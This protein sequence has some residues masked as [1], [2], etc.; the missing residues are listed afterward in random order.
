MSD[1]AD[2]D[3]QKL[4]KRWRSGDPEAGQ[5][6]AQRFSDWYYAITTVRLGDTRGRGPLERACNSFAQGIV[7]VSKSSELVDWAH[8]LVAKE[9]AEA[10][11]RV[12]GGDFPNALTDNRSPSELLQQV[13]SK[14]S[15]DELKLLNYAY[16]HTADLDTLTTEAEAQGGMPL[17]LLQARYALKR[18]LRDS[19]NVPLSV[20]PEE[21]NLDLAPLPL[22]EAGRMETDEEEDFFEQW[23]IT[24]LEL[25]QD[26][27]EFATFS[28]A[29]RAGALANVRGAQ[30]S[31]DGSQLDSPERSG[32]VGNKIFMLLGFLV[33]LGV[34]AVLVVGIALIFMS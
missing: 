16:G 27:A 22:Y 30:A 14:M 9:L 11:S 6:M 2:Q 18:H 31:A 33:A 17:S 12:E 13:G 8:S 3:V 25:C 4:F 29:L 26:V 20:A 28:H 1:K 21:P 23:L 24:D 32:G 7:G 10:G 19:A 5:V 34:L 15:P